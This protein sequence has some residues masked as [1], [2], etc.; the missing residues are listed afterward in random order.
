MFSP[1]PKAVNSYVE[2]IVVY[3]DGDTRK[4]R[5]PRMEQLGFSERYIKERYRKYVEN[6]TEDNN[7]A[8]WPDAVRFIAKQNDTRAVPIKYVVLVHH[9]AEI[10]PGASGASAKWQEYLFYGG[11]VSFVEIPR[12]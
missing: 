7:R 3:A 9:W 11:E 4:W 6:L 12:R 5:F 10:T 8:L 2:G 1:L